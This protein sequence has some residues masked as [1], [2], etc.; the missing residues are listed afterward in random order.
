MPVPHISEEKQRGSGLLWTLLG[1]P[2]AAVLGW[3]GY[4][5][6]FIPHNMP[7]PPALPGERKEFHGRAGRLS[8]YV[9]GDGPPLL[10]IHSVNAAAS[11]YEMRPMFERY[12]QSRR[13]YALDSPGFGFSDRSAR[14]YTPRLFTDAVLDMLDEIAREAGSEP[15]DVVGLSLG[16]EFVARA[17]SEHP[18]RFATI[19]LVTPTGFRKGD[20]TMYGEPGS[21][22]AIPLMREFFELPGIN[23]A[24]F[25][26]LNSRP[27]ARYFLKQT[28]GS[29]ETIDQ[30]LQEY[31]YLTSHQ[32]DAWHAPYAFVSGHLF[33]ADISRI[34]ESLDLPVWL[35]YGTKGQFSDFS[36]MQSIQG[37]ANWVV[38]S[39]DTGAIIYFE[40]PDQFFAA[41]DAFLERVQAII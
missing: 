18:E 6:L 32:P 26:L 21:T 28:F 34:Y 37:H 13:V 5:A 14:E 27:S 41:Y 8:Y 38:Q 10:L 33:S 9:A 16:A 39:F 23:R 31:D 22:R 1:A 29:Y 2:L 20:D 12:R 17:A 25:D 30:G 3:A 11:S 19:A 40:Q 35:A 24:F 4:S 36:N 7:L 15:L